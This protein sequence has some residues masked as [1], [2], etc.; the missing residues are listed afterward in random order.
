ML[1]AYYSRERLA[2]FGIFEMRACVLDGVYWLPIPRGGYSL[3]VT[4][5][6]SAARSAVLDGRSLC[7]AGT[8]SAKVGR[9]CIRARDAR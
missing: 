8:R 2:D 4:K 7:D 3:V 6:K 9:K 1:Y 5:A